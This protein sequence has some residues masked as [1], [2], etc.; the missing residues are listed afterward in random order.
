[1]SD[2]E[3]KSPYFS[4]TIKIKDVLSPKDLTGLKEFSLEITMGNQDAIVIK[5]PNDFGDDSN[6][7]DI[8]DIVEEEFKKRDEWAKARNLS[9]VDQKVK[10]AGDVAE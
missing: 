4:K 10:F 6:R 9:F 5:D 7:K 2:L 3:P 8:W 1:M